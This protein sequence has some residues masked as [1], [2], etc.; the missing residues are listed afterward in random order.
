MTPDAHTHDPQA[1]TWKPTPN[2]RRALSSSRALYARPWLLALGFRVLPKGVVTRSANR[3]P[4]SPRPRILAANLQRM[5]DAQS[6]SHRV[7]R[8]ARPVSVATHQAHRLWNG[9]GL[10]APS[11]RREASWPLLQP[12]A[13]TSSVARW[14]P[15]RKA[16][17]QRGPLCVGTQK[18]D[19]SRRPLSAAPMLVNIR[20]E[21]N[22]LAA[23]KPFPARI[24]TRIAATCK[25]RFD[26]AD[27]WGG[28]KHASLP[29]D[30]I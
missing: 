3:I 6:W 28:A 26:G 10:L 19:P 13:S 21:N 25:A 8:R 23:K 11:M 14:A 24:P 5:L 1:L 12:F 7:S 30:E 15:Y 20:S 4:Q 29:E 22:V 18:S 2:S 9:W 27:A 17:P 16:G